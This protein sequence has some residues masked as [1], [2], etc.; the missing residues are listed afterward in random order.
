MRGSDRSGGFL[1]HAA[2]LAWKDL[3]VELRT[4]EIVYSMTLFA[5][6]V[7]LVFS[8]AFVR[9]GQASPEVVPG[10]LWASLAL[11]G[12]IGLGRAFDREREGDTLRALLL[13]PV[14]RASL[15]VGKAVAIAVYML[16]MEVVT[17]PLVA[18]LFH[19]DLRPAALLVAP[20]LLLATL[21]FA[22]VG[23][24]FAAMLLRVRAREM[25][26]PVILYPILVPLLIAGVKGTDA[27]LAAPADLDSARFWVT[28]LLAYDAVVLCLALWAFEPLTTE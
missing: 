3:L 25:L 21:G 28:F 14:S 24:V 8:F 15:F 17:T 11:A 20:L 18:L 6:L 10:I 13:A 1:R 27:L 23:A 5:V 2:T 22:A 4:R 7:V 26:L 19:V 12:T 16:A 9:Q